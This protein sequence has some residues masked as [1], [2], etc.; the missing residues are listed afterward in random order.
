MTDIQAAVGIKQLE[1]LDF[2][3][4]ERR[5][6]A[7]KYLNELKNI[8]GIILPKEEDGYLTNFQSFSVIVEPSA[9]LS[10]NEL[11]QAL[12]ENNIS[13][14]RGVMT[15]H[16]ETAYKNEYTDCKLPVSEGLSDNS[17]ILPLYYPMEQRDI[18]T[19]ISVLKKLLA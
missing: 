17:I 6:I 5:K 11:M 19:V 7:H 16:R 15:A 14:R 9:K 4:S 8:P 13:S 1:K 18:D 10:R 12:L 2:I 3:I